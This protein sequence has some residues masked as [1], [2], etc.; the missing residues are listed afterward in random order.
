MMHYA[1]LHLPT[2]THVFTGWYIEEVEN[3]LKTSFFYKD[4]TTQ[5]IMS[6]PYE[7]GD[8]E[9]VTLNEDTKEIIGDSYFLIKLNECEFEIVEVY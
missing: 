7:L 1:L 2:A 3:F 9:Y 4:P 5:E 8:V 6:K